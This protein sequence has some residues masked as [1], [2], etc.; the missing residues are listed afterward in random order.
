M[1]IYFCTTLVLSR[2][3]LYSWMEEYP[4]DLIRGVSRESTA[5]Y[6]PSCLYGAPCACILHCALLFPNK[7]AISSFFVPQDCCEYC[8]LIVLPLE[9]ILLQT[10][11]LLRQSRSS[12]QHVL[13]LSFPD[14]DSWGQNIQSGSY[15][16]RV[17]LQIARDLGV[18]QESLQ[19][20]ATI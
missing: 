19:G 14:D 4:V 8:R 15:F 3:I 11:T 12:F 1:L 10:K 6:K 2:Q 16:I 20:S 9:H 5:S 17:L 13:Y 7:G 18:A